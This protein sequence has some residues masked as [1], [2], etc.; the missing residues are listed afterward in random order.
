MFNKKTAKRI[1]A[2]FLVS[3]IICCLTACS[4]KLNGTYTTK[5]GL[6]EQSFIFKEDN[7]VAV[8]AF[9]LE[10]EGDYVIEDGKLTITYSILG[11]KYDVD[12]DFEKKGS[13]IFINGVEFIK[14]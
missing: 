8:S 7:R 6:I 12:M 4:I 13:S 10:V 1:V 5:D 14:E 9:D 3:L 11:L 2:F